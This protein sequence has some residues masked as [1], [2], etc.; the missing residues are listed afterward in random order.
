[1]MGGT[2]S[3]TPSITFVVDN[4]ND[5]IY[6]ATSDTGISWNDCKIKGTPSSGT[7]NVTIAGTAHDNIEGAYD[8]ITTTGD[9]T[10]GDEIIIVAA[11]TA[12][13]DVDISLVYEP[14]NAVLGTWTV[15]V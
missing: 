15:N 7:V 1:M 12:T 14:T 11:S 5:K 13:G 3:K 6:V 4:T 10:A 9:V 2:Q 8:T